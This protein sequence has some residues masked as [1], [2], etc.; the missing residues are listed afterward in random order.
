MKKLSLI[1]IAVIFTS[2]CYAQDIS[3]NSDYTNMELSFD[4]GI[5]QEYVEPYVSMAESKDSTSSRNEFRSAIN[6][7]PGGIAFGIFSINFEYLIK[8]KHGLVAR[9]DYE[10]VP[11]TYTEAL[12]DAYGIGFTLNYRYHFSGEM[13]SLF[14]GAYARYRTYIGTGTSEAGEFDF[15]IPEYTFGLNA[16]KRWAWNNGLNVT[17][18]L[19]YGFSII[20]REV[21]PSNEYNESMVD[22]FEDD[23]NFSGPFY[24]ELSIGYAF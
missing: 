2:L 12:I 18:A 1:T 8:P 19:G 6:M 14:L 11:K 7:C 10:A 20:N 22:N 15:T 3:T 17:L 23:Y 5:E 24:G 13:N 4:F 16:G 21:E 9:F